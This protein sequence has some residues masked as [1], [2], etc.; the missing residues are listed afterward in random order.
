MVLYLTNVHNPG[1]KMPKRKSSN[2]PYLELPLRSR[3]QAMRDI[4]EARRRKNQRE[5]NH[6]QNN[7][8]T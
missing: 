4:E 8:E 1:E 3:E 5:P 6:D 2:S 7:S